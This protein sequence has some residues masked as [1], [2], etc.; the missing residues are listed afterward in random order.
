MKQNNLA[1]K[2]TGILKVYQLHCEKPTLVENI[3]HKN[4]REKFVALDKISLEIKKG[5]KV[6][7]VGSNGSGKTTLLKIISG[8]TTPN[9]G[10]VQTRGRLVSLI[11][12]SAGFHPE[13]TG[14][15]NIYQNAMLLGMSRDE[16]KNKLE[17]IIEYADIG[18]FIN[19]PM[20]TYSDG[21]KLR[22]GFSIAVAANPDILVLDEGIV[23]GDENFHRKSIKKIGEMISEGKTMLMASHWIEYLRENCQ[24]IIW[25]ADGKIKMDGGIE[26]LEKYLKFNSN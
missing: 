21:M 1:I 24:R 14:R 6:G 8:I 4:K 17:K 25:I 16:I 5:E 7:L 13:L 15:E 3:F 19:V 2:L 9:K 11:D 20:Y 10:R 22:L 12:L 18:D 23:V 26:I